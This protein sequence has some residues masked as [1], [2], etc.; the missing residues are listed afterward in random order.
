MRS[1][2]MAPLKCL[3]QRGEVLVNRA[4]QVLTDSPLK[5]DVANLGHER[6]TVC[7]AGR[8]FALGDCV[9]VEGLDAPLTKDIYP[10]EAMCDIIV[11][12]LKQC[13]RTCPGVLHEL[14]PSLQQPCLV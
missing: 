6:A 12:N 10:A 5:D 3:N 9:A 14:K 2:F 11:A 1:S 7:G 13:L 4:M 8:I